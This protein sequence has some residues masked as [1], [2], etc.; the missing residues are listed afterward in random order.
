VIV[1]GSVFTWVDLKMSKA[2]QAAFFNSAIG[3]S[4]AASFRKDKI[5]DEPSG[6][7][8]LQLIP[9]CSITVSEL[10]PFDCD[11]IVV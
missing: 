6:E 11:A 2:Q 1:H 5:R 9:G 10:L 8:S 7:V 3:A 4:F